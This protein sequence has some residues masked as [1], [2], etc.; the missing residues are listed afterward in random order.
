ML[1]VVGRVLAILFYVHSNAD[2]HALARPFLQTIQHGS[3]G[4][5]RVRTPIF[6]PNWSSAMT[7]LHRIGHSYEDGNLTDQ[8]MH[9]VL[10]D[11]KFAATLASRKLASPPMLPPS[12]SVSGAVAWVPVV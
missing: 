3:L 12:L 10:I 4:P 2:R 7:T 1:S 8:S 5:V 9:D 11:S 6:H